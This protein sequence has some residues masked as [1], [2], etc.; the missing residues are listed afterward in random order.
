MSTTPIPGRHIGAEI[1][2]EF[3]QYNGIG[4]SWF[5]GDWNS[6]SNSFDVWGKSGETKLHATWDEG[7]DELTNIKKIN[8]EN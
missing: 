8:N 2:D 6:L 7:S 1:R 4:V 5:I 3:M